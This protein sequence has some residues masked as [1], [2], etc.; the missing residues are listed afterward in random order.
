MPGRTWPTAGLRGTVSRPDWRLSDPA[1]RRFDPGHLNPPP[2]S[3]DTAGDGGRGPAGRLLPSEELC[4]AA[5]L[6]RKQG[7]GSPSYRRERLADLMCPAGE[8]PGAQ[9]D[10]AAG[11]MGRSIP[12]LC[13]DGG[14]AAGVPAGLRIRRREGRRCSNWSAE[15][16]SEKFWA[17]CNKRDL[18][19]IM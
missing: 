4:T 11:S 13:S 14:G 2:S 1:G 16:I 8:R 6:L 15:K 7:G 18:P 17:P 10:A 19:R 3:L 9:T 12:L 5:R